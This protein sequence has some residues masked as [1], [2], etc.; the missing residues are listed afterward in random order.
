MH[1]FVWSPLHKNNREG[2]LPMKNANSLIVLA[3]ALLLGACVG[4]ESEGTDDA[5]DTSF[6]V[7]GGGMTLTVS[8][9]TVSGVVDSTNPVSFCATGIPQGKTLDVFF[10]MP[11]GSQP[12][13]AIT[14]IL[15]DAAGA[16]CTSIPDGIITAPG[17]QPLAYEPGRVSVW[18]Y[19]YNYPDMT[20]A[21]RSVGPRSNFM[22]Q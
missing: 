4:Q 11:R 15:P 21:N 16:G 18:S 2:F 17:P 20:S 19:L 12:N 3:A 9:S 10:D 13:F 8:P 5:D 7:K 1:R 14:R 22:V 6:E